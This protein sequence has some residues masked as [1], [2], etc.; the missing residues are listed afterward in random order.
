[1]NFP[2]AIER[3]QKEPEFEKVTDKEF[4]TAFVNATSL[5]LLNIFKARQ[6][7]ALNDFNQGA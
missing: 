1:M 7:I 6:D 2:L 5:Q 4:I 3:F